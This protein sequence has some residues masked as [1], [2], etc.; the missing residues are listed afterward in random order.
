MLH[1]VHT[2]NLFIFLNINNKRLKNVESKDKRKCLK[3]GDFRSLLRSPKT[4]K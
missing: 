2:F 3:M 4:K 1:V